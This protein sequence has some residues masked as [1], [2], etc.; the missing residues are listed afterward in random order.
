MACVHICSVRKYTC[1][2]DVTPRPPPFTVRANIAKSRV[3]MSPSVTSPGERPSREAR[4]PLPPPLIVLKKSRESND[5]QSSMDLLLMDEPLIEAAN[6]LAS[7]SWSRTGLNRSS[8]NWSTSD[9]CDGTRTRLTCDAI[10]YYN[11]KIRK[12]NR[13][14]KS[15]EAQ[16]KKGFNG[17]IIL[18]DLRMRLI[19]FFFGNVHF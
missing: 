4:L 15:V 16:K 9:A 10:I 5:S 11:P 1:G 2:C 3:P 12:L 6:D 17:Y 18:Y 19:F 14:K 7:D 13:W 8:R